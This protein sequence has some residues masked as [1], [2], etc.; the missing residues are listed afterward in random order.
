M[1]IYVDRE[2]LSEEPKENAKAKI[3]GLIVSN[4][5]T[6]SVVCTRVSTRIHEQFRTNDCQAS[7]AILG[8]TTSKHAIHATDSLSICRDIRSYS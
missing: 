2:S 7:T 4:Y 3:F 8:T 5:C 6:E 1:G